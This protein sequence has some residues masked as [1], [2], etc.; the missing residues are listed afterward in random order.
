MRF[1]KLGIFLLLEVALFFGLI[2]LAD[3][4]QYDDL[5]ARML[6][7]LL[8]TQEFV[9]GSAVFAGIWVTYKDWQK[10]GVVSHV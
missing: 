9:L 4:S 3:I 8:V 10:A 1:V 7:I 2:H 6:C 5:S